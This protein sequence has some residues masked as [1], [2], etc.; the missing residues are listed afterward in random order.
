MVATHEILLKAMEIYDVDLG[1]FQDSFKVRF[2]FQKYAYVTQTIVGFHAGNYNLYIRGP[3]S[4]EVANIGYFISEN[5][6]TLMK[7]ISKLRFSPNT[8]AKLKLIKKI[9][10]SQ[11]G[12]SQT[13]ALEAWTTYHYIRTEFF[14]KPDFKGAL[15]WL[16]KLKPDLENKRNTII[17]MIEAVD[18]GLNT[19]YAT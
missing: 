16:F 18:K 17:K 14:P 12:L 8:A 19:T 13:E 10:T 11:S 6:K 7:A 4:P 5:H 2:L 1:D 9:F 15:A 3:Y